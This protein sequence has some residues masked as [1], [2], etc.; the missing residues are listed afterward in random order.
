[1]EKPLT[2]INRDESYHTL[3]NIATRQKQVLDVI[4]H[5][6]PIHNRKIANKL[7]L[8][9]NSVTGRVKELRNL[10]LVA[11]CGKVKDDVTNRT[12]TLFESIN[13]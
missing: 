10:G 3:D 2:E 8:P 13:N 1:M 4:K 11:I 9:I 12:V 7:K 6:E 5:H